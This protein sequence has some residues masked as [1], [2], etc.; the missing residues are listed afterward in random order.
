VDAAIIE[1]DPLP[2]PIGAAAK[3][4]DLPFGTGGA[5]F[6]VAA[7]VGGIIVGGVGLELGRAGVN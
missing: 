3:N 5:A 6:V 2:Y 7:I 4:H 1:L